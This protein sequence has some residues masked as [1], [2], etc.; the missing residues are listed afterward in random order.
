VANKWLKVAHFY[1]EE[2][3]MRNDSRRSFPRSGLSSVVIYLARQK[4]KSC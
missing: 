1:Q 4:H 3:R 2:Y